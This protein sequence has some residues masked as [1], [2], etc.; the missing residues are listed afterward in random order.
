M[1]RDF[2]QLLIL[3]LVFFAFLSPI[4]LTKGV[5]E[6]VILSD[7]AAS[8]SAVIQV[9]LAIVGSFLGAFGGAWVIERNQD[10][11]NLLEELRNTNAAVMATFHI[12]S[13]MLNRKKNDILPVIQD[14]ELQKS[15]LKKAE[16]GAGEIFRPN[17]SLLEVFLLNL[18]TLEDILFRRLNLNAKA[19]AAY[20]ELAKFT[21]L[22]DTSITRRNTKLEKWKTEKFDTIVNEFFGFSTR[23]NDQ[24]SSGNRGD[25]TFPKNLDAMHSYV[26]DC[27]FYSMLLCKELI[28]HGKK[29]HEKLAN[30]DDIRPIDIRFED[31]N[32]D[33]IPERPEH[34]NWLNQFI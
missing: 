21:S 15:A 32:S 9:L 3:T 10:K 17:F 16:Q 29:L 30:S 18:A 31:I 6:A 13:S 20:S 25:Q 7:G 28:R 27:I 4:W 34:K 19:L 23:Q 22:L 26:D 2:F 12:F 5:H 1:K 14:F 11:K 33:L 8:N 24:K